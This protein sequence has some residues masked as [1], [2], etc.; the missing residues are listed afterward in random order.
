MSQTAR[1][2][3]RAPG[4]IRIRRPGARKTIGTPPEIREQFPHLRQN[5]I[6]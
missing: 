6:S 4:E 1:G 5:L 3:P 2:T